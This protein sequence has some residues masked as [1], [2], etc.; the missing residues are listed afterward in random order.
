MYRAPPKDRLVTM[1]LDIFEYEAFFSQL[2]KEERQKGDKE[3]EKDG[4]NRTLDPV[5]DRNEIIAIQR[6]AVRIR[7]NF[8]QSQYRSQGTDKHHT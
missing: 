5:K 6:R 2:L 1:A 3:H 7:R 4:E 8:T